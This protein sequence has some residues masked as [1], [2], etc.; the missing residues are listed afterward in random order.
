MTGWTVQTAPELDPEMQVMLARIRG[1]QQPA[2]EAMPS[3][4]PARIELTSTKQSEVSGRGA[5]VER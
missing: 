3:P 1:G 4:V 2:T 5:D